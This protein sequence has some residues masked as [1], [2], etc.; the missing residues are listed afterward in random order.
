M[1]GIEA[2]VKY[3]VPSAAS[4]WFFATVTDPSC[5]T[6]KLNTAIYRNGAGLNNSDPVYYQVNLARCAP[7]SVPTPTETP[8]PRALRVI[9]TPTPVG[10]SLHGEIHFGLGNLRVNP[11]PF[12][13][14]GT[15]VFFDVGK[16]VVVDVTLNI[17]SSETKK[18][19]RS[20][21]A[22][23]FHKGEGNQV[24]YNAQDDDGKL[25]GPGSYV[26]EVEAEQKG[27]KETIS[28]TFNFTK[29][30]RGE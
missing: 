1:S 3:Y 16:D 19:V 4:P 25:L 17:Y 26:F 23:T 15:F 28:G 22:G 30:R 9:P 10:L 2:T 14:A 21:K 20:L 13:Y 12:T 18:M 27:H 29:K 8:V 6:L 7:T 11:D 24:F 5:D